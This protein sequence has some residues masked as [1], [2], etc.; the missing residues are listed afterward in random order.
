MGCNSQPLKPEE[1][2]ILLGNWKKFDEKFDSI[3]D[4]IN[5]DLLLLKLA[6]QEPNFSGE[7]CKRVQTAGAKEK[8]RQVIGRPHLTIP[9][10]K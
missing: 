10:F 1:W 8:C 5:K 9:T 6:V 7:L 2:K 4:P 3:K